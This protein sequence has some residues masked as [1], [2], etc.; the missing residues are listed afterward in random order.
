MFLPVTPQQLNRM[1]AWRLALGAIAVGFL[2]GTVASLIESHRVEQAALENASE[3]VRHFQS[4][5]M[6]ALSGEN[7]IIGHEAMD[8]LLARS[9]LAAIRVFTPADIPIYENWGGLAETVKHTLSASASQESGGRLSIGG[10]ELLRVS[11]PLIGKTGSIGRLEGLWRID[12]GTL[13]A[14]RE[15]IFTSAL[16]A[17]LSV[18]AAALLLYPLMTGLLGHATHLSSR[19]LDSNLSLLRSLGN[20]VAKRD[21]ETDAHNYRVTLYAVAL[22]EAIGLPKQDIAHLV[23]GAFL[24]DVGKIGIPDRILLKPGKLTGEEFEIMKTHALL[25]L[26]IVAGN[27]WMEQAACVIRHHHERFDGGGYPDGLV[28]HAIPVIARVFAIADVFDALT[29]ERPYKKAIAPSSA[30]AMIEEESG[31]HFDPDVVASFVK[32]AVQLHLEIMGADSFGLRSRMQKM[33]SRYFGTEGG[34]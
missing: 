3:A 31:S 30:L 27:A 9:N 16:T 8:L 20:A 14:W 29:S 6:S 32:I 13:S 25:G 18:F 12:S 7:S 5:A 23:A 21:S 26:E 28:G 24:H 2:A 10:E 15:R 19:L 1:L 33:I 11:I 17:A 4:P 22:A 34:D